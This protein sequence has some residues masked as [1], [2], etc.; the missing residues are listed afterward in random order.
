MD[1]N[2]IWASRSFS[3]KFFRFRP[4][5]SKRKKFFNQRKLD[6][7]SIIQE[8]INWFFS[9]D[10]ANRKSV[11]MQAQPRKVILT[12]A[13]WKLLPSTIT[14]CTLFGFR[15]TTRSSSRTCTPSSSPSCSSKTNMSA[16]F[17]RTFVHSSSNGRLSR[18]RT[19]RL[20]WKS[21]RLISTKRLPT[22]PKSKWMVLKRNGTCYLAVVYAKP[23][24]ILFSLGLWKSA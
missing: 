8:S 18:S 24:S 3:F 16:T 14:N 19:A 13:I 12:S 20:C 5:Q 15:A 21:H 9:S 7:S 2:S 10:F 22:Y 1:M 6:S 17:S 23:T 11:K 4:K